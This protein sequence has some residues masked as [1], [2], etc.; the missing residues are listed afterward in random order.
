[1]TVDLFACMETIKKRLDNLIIFFFN[2]SY[3]TSY[4]GLHMHGISTF[5]KTLCFEDINKKNLMALAKTPVKK[6]SND[7]ENTGMC[8]LSLVNLILKL[9][10]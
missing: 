10:K 8:K 1:M 9:I 5:I 2:M 6:G 3:V 7:G 4:D